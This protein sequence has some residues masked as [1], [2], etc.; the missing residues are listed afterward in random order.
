[1]RRGERA[2]RCF[3]PIPSDEEGREGG[4]GRFHQETNYCSVR[5]GDFCRFFN[6]SNTRCVLTTCVHEAVPL[7]Y[8]CLRGQ[9]FCIFISKHG[10]ES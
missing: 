10:F 9:I 5:R 7:D 8:R 3:D 4:G 2:A 1:M 6:P